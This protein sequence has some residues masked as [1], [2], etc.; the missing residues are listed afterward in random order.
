MDI[1][2]AI[3]LRLV[4]NFLSSQI[5]PESV[6]AEIVKLKADLEAY[7][8][9]TPSKIDDGILSALERI[10]T[11]DTAKAVEAEILTLAASLA[12][13]TATDI[14]DQLVVILKKAFQV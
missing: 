13:T 10:V 7:V 3:A 11:G 8:A 4:L 6:D 14:D 9:K 2:Q 1:F 12:A 5:N